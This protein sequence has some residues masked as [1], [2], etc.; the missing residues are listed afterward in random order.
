MTITKSAVSFF[1]LLFIGFRSLLSQ[2]IPEDWRAKLK[3]NDSGYVDIIQ[4]FQLWNTVTLQSE[5]DSIDPRWDLY[6]R[7]ARFGLSG[8][9][10]SRINFYVG[11]T[12]DG[13]GKDKYTASNGVTNPNDNSTFNIRDAFFTY[14]YKEWLNVTM[15][16]FRP[17]AGKESIYTSALN[18]SQEKGQPSFHPRVH[19][20]GRPLGRETGINI[21]GLSVGKCVSF[22]YDIGLFDVNHPAIVGNGSY[23]SP[24]FTSRATLMLGDPEMKNYK[25][26]YSQNGYLERKGLSIA[27]NLTYQGKTEIF[28]QNM[29]LGGDF[30][31]NYGSL[32]L[33]GE[34]L[35]LYRDNLLEN[36]ARNITID[37][38]YVIKGAW[39]ILL[40]KKQ[41]LQI[42]L[43]K[44]A[45]RPDNNYSLTQFNNLTKASLHSEIAAGVNWMLNRN[46]LKLGLHFVSG[47]KQYFTSNSSRVGQFMYINPSLQ[48][49]L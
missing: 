38:S 23:W 13:I 3:L 19:M 33:I 47:S 10:N 1:I 41:I 22:L 7:R 30:Q 28:K 32:D 25:L 35:Y 2:D 31:L 8:Q 39:N 24:L 45:T 20:V 44:T 49:M 15:G 4:Y 46:K 21:G 42:C 9:L 34:Y 27:A 29:V 36:N 37:N 26:V 17:R 5:R 11:F 16:Y 6:L 40:K 14:K 12:Y 48:W 18:I 43:M